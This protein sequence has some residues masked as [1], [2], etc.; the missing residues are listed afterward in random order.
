MGNDIYRMVKRRMKAAKLPD[1]L[2]PHSFRVCV[3]T[4][5]LE[6]GA[7][8]EEVQEL[9]GHSDPRTTKLYRRTKKKVT[10]NL[11]ERISE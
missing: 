6:H 7:E 8:L 2:R 4:D 5:L 1:N 3:A 10:R 9:L 11:V